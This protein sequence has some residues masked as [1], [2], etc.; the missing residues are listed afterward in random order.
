MSRWLG[1]RSS[2][3]KLSC[4][5]PELIKQAKKYFRCGNDLNIRV[6]SKA[7]P[8]LQKASLKRWH[9]QCTNPMSANSGAD[10]GP[11]NIVMGIGMKAQLIVVLLCF[12]NCF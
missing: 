11:P 2:P 1:E 7:D 5:A 12:I 8:T 4:I 6:G 10:C 9:S 3:I